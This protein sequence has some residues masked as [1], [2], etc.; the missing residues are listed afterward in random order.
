MLGILASSHSVFKVTVRAE[1]VNLFF[2]AQFCSPCYRTFVPI[3]TAIA[4]CIRRYQR[5]ACNAADLRT[6]N[7]SGLSCGL[8]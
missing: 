1:I 2:E 6:A 8:I 5:A 3:Y 7:E 4:A